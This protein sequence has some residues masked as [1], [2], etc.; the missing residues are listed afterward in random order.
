MTHSSITAN[1]PGITPSDCPGALAHLTDYHDRRI[2]CEGVL[3]ATIHSYQCQ[4]CG[5]M[6]DLD[7]L[8]R[9]KV[10]PPIV[11]DL[12]RAMTRG[13]TNDQIRMPKEGPKSE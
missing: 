7:D 3:V 5:T 11:G 6:L 9:L 12:A 13:M 2:T 4:A 1:R 8:G 10:F